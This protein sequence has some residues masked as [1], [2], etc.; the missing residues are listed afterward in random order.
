MSTLKTYLV[1]STILLWSVMGMAQVAEPPFSGTTVLSY[2]TV[3][4]SHMWEAGLNVGMPLVLGDVEVQSGTGVGMHLRRALDYVFSVRG[5]LFIADMKN[6]DPVDGKTKTA[7]QSGTIDVIASLNNLVWTESKTKKTNFYGFLSI[8]TNRFKVQV[9][10]LISQEIKSKPFSLQTHG[11]GGAGFSLRVNENLNVGLESKAFVLFGKEADRLDGVARRERDVLS[12]T[13]IRLNYNIGNA[14]K[15]T[16]PLYWINPMI[17]IQESVTELKKRPVYDMTDSDGDGVIDQIDHD[18]NT[19]PNVQVDTRGLALDSDGDGI[20]NHEDFEPYIPSTKEGELIGEEYATESDVERIV[21]DRMTEYDETGEVPLPGAEGKGGNATEIDLA[22][23][24]KKETMDDISSLNWFLP[25]LHFDI[26]SYE[27]QETDHSSLATVGK[28]LA[29]NPALK[30]VVTGYADNTA[31]PTYNNLLSYKR[32]EQTILY[33]VETFQLERDRL[34]L[35]FNGENDP[36][37]PSTGSSLMNRRVEFRV[38]EEQDE[39]MMPPIV[40]IE[41][42][43]K[44]ER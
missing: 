8:G 6:A 34:L 38:A 4:P 40:P 14:D 11:G 39:E 25:I 29:G 37:V 16:E 13:S 35:H 31:S 1:F 20:P 28:L 24:P 22:P 2:H 19:P 32:A 21:T 17:A 18:N 44:E 12:Y 15:H 9:I 5:E 3:T 36:L 33:L 10:E 23:S 7:W 30:L 42:K 41:R 26:D 27:L 43:K